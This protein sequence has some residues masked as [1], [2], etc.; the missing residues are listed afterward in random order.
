MNHLN[1]SIQVAAG[2]AV[3]WTAFWL[4]TNN[5]IITEFMRPSVESG[6]LGAA[7]GN[8]LSL[9]IEILTSVGVVVIA[10]SIRL[11]RYLADLLE[12]LASRI[13]NYSTSSSDVKTQKSDPQRLLDDLSK[14]LIQAVLEA[15]RPLTIQLAHR[16]AKKDFLD[17]SA[18]GQS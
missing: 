15:D 17:T 2:I 13:T 9:L 3:F 7:A 11:L 1:K 12:P 16:L 10:V 4:L 18:E 6:Q 8:A 14:L 5:Q